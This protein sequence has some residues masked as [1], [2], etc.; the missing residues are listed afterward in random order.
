MF[1]LLKRLF[2]FLSNEELYSK[3]K[4]IVS[5]LNKM[6]TT[7]IEFENTFLDNIENILA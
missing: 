3:H 4:A 7:P 2:N 1:K 6:K 5:P